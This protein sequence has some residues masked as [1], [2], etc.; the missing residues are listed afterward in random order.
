M[1]RVRRWRVGGGRN[2]QDID[3]DDCR[4]VADITGGKYFQAEDAEALTDMLLNLPNA[5][6]LQ[7]RKVEITVWFALAGALLVLAGVGLAQ[8]WN[9]PGFRATRP[10]G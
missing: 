2:V 1:G 7:H 8:W 10:T 5:I 4:Q 3:E 9:R 6:V